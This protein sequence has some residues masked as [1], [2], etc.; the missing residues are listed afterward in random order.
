MTYYYVWFSCF[1]IVAYLIA[2]DESVARFVVL[3]TKIAKFQYE[4]TKW[5]ILYNPANPV[6]KYIIWR[7]SMEIAK[8]L[9]SEFIKEDLNGKNDQN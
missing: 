4:K 7:R 2:T 6:V 3:L 9:Q 8:Q 1:T 5:W